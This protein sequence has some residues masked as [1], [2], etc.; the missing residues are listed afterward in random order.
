MK[1]FIRKFLS[2]SC[3]TVLS[4]AIPTPT[5]S[6]I[7]SLEIWDG[8][9]KV[10]MGDFHTYPGSFDC[11][12]VTKNIPNKLLEYL[13][14]QL[15]DATKK[16]NEE[17]TKLLVLSD[18]PFVILAENSTSDQCIFPGEIESSSSTIPS[19]PSLFQEI[20]KSLREKYRKT[21]E[22]NASNNKN[23][24][25]ENDYVQKHILKL[26]NTRYDLITSNVLYC[27]IIE[28]F[29]S[30]EDKM[31]ENDSYCFFEELKEI[32]KNLYKIHNLATENLEEIN[33]IRTLLTLKVME[34]VDH[35]SFKILSEYYVELN[36]YS[37]YLN[38]LKTQ[39]KTTDIDSATGMENL[40]ICQQLTNETMYYVDGL[41]R[42]ILQYD[43][44]ETSMGILDIQF[45]N[46]FLSN[47]KKAIYQISGAFHCKITKSLIEFLGLKKGASTRN[48]TLDKFQLFHEAALLVQHLGIYEKLRGLKSES[49][50]EEDLEKRII[51]DALAPAFAIDG[52]NIEKLLNNK[53][54]EEKDQ[55]I[56]KL[57]ETI[58][59]QIFLLDE[60]DKNVVL[61]IFV[62]TCPQPIK[63]CELCEKESLKNKISEYFHKLL[64][65]SPDSPKEQPN[66]QQ[67][68]KKTG[69]QSLAQFLLSTKQGLEAQDINLIMEDLLEKIKNPSSD[70][71][72]STNLAKEY[73]QEDFVE[74]IMGFNKRII[75]EIDEEI[76]RRN[77]LTDKI[78]QLIQSIT[79]PVK[80][81]ISRH[82][83]QNEEE[84]FC[85]EAIKKNLD[86]IERGISFF[87]TCKEKGDPCEN[88][89]KLITH[90]KEGIFS[91]MNLLSVHCEHDTPE[92]NE[93]IE[94]RKDLANNIRHTIKQIEV[95]DEIIKKIPTRFSVETLEE[96]LST[97]PVVVPKEIVEGETLEF[98]RT[99]EE[100]YP[101]LINRRNFI[102]ESLNKFTT[103]TTEIQKILGGSVKR[104]RPINF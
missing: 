55:T 7:I 20:E 16:Q 41:I 88:I 23:S 3:L 11:D 49:Y 70:I 6:I 56:T 84:I 46:N 17:I 19:L 42:S 43:V 96:A 63:E 60:T 9:Q 93:I 76:N 8:G 73:T 13:R 25:E 1:T 4:I 102:E 58:S 87:K 2:F 50:P 94:S 53:T 64:P 90:L 36:K 80:D 24:M 74:L 104:P 37:Q 78:H 45:F 77:F 21:L 89:C 18:K 62:Q 30:I 67:E 35:K 79:D 57:A 61:S 28:L 75:T 83:I 99:K 71:K 48:E 86:T 72:A 98:P 68:A 39:C 95:L 59:D 5:K 52:D 51:K 29:K 47:E 97:N 92:K 69:S 54:I 91:N 12:F 34:D 15:I 38:S 101:E 40:K 44:C 82:K 10:L 66:S 31:K 65:K 32:N 103:I 85:Y 33:R 100:T 14:K 27:E 26:D 81:N 22:S